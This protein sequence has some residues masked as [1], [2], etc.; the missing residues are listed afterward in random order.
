MAC[1]A[2]PLKVIGSGLSLALGDWRHVVVDIA[3]LGDFAAPLD[4]QTTF[5]RDVS[6][7]GFTG[8]PHHTYLTPLRIKYL[9]CKWQ[10]AAILVDA[11][12]QY[13]PTTERVELDQ[14]YCARGRYDVAR[15]LLELYIHRH[16]FRIDFHRIIL[17][18][19]Q[20]GHD[21]E[22][23]AVDPCTAAPPEPGPFCTWHMHQRRGFA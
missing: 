2:H 12:D 19:R 8:L 14:R 10:R 3:L 15:R 7:E 23:A 22:P 17:E 16:A 6:D 13:R 21:S 18:R 5:L 4:G 11:L 20:I 1:H 9:C